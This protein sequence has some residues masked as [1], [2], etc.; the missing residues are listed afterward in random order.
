MSIFYKLWKGGKHRLLQLVVI[1]D[2]VLNKTKINPKIFE[3]ERML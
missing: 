2:F 3:Q 1:F